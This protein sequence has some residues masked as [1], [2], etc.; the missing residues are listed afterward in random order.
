MG[1]LSF[2]LLW[3]FLTLAHIM[4]D[5]LDLSSTGYN[6]RGVFDGVTAHYDRLATNEAR[7]EHPLPG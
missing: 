6:A 7:A 3:V 4:L 5:L 1:L 2:D